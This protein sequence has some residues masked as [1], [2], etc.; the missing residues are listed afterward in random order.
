MKYFWQIISVC[1]VV[2][3][4]GLGVFIYNKCFKKDNVEPWTPEKYV[5]DAE[6]IECEPTVF[7]VKIIASEC[8]HEEGEIIKVKCDDKRYNYLV[9]GTCVRI[10]TWDKITEADRDVSVYTM[11]KLTE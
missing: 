2:V 8:G 6:I 4:I 10:I 5:I 9:V 3:I 7:T 1:A 11:S